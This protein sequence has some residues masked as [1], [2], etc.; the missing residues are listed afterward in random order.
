M[1]NNY[2]DRIN[3]SDWPLTALYDWFETLTDV[4]GDIHPDIFEA[5]D[6][7]Y[8]INQQTRIQDFRDMIFSKTNHCGKLCRNTCNA[9]CATAANF[10]SSLEVA[11]LARYSN[12][13][14]F[15]ERVL[16]HFFFKLSDAISQF[17]EKYRIGV[18]ILY[19]DTPELVDNFIEK[20][21][22]I[23]MSQLSKQFYAT[24]YQLVD[25]RNNIFHHIKYYIDA[26]V[27]IAD[28]NYIRRDDLVEYYQVLNRFRFLNIF[29]VKTA[30]IADTPDNDIRVHFENILPRNK[31]IISDW[32]HKPEELP[33]TIRKCLTAALRLKIAL[34]SYFVR[35]N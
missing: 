35:K 9:E 8:T 28:R 3:L 26:V 30:D 27:I 1:A 4:K 15:E 22:R 13:Q 17:H 11:E 2:F 18:L 31:I 14:P 24:D 21:K 29:I 10:R 32:L 7:T 19:L 20:E 25:A 16:T 23:I 12:F 6:V 5:L 34:S 33:M